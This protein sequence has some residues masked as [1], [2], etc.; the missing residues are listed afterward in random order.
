M[1]VVVGIRGAVKVCEDRC[2]ASANIREI[3][4]VGVIVNV[5]EF[6]VVPVIFSKLELL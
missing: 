4:G 5:C 6:R 1:A 2:G 3:G